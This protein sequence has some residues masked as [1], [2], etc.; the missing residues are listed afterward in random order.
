MNKRL[1]FVLPN[2]L[3][4]GAQR[5]N[6]EIANHLATDYGYKVSIIVLDDSSFCLPLIL[7]RIELIQCH[8]AFDSLRVHTPRLATSGLCGKLEV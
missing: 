7:P 3:Q 6:I 8:V 5:V 2:L 4:G 1:L